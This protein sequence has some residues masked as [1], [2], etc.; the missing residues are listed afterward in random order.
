MGKLKM[1]HRST[2]EIC[3]IAIIVAVGNPGHVFFA[4]LNALNFGLCEK[5]LKIKK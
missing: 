5:F 3:V 2:L 1:L 4:I